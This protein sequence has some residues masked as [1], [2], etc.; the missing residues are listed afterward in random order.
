MGRRLLR[1]LDPAW[2]RV[3]RGRFS[4]DP[5]SSLSARPCRVPAP[6]LGP[7]LQGIV[8]LPPARAVRG[9]DRPVYVSRAALGST[10]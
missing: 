2:G 4:M 1:G 9:R 6:V 8:C 7:R 10:L 5:G 3:L